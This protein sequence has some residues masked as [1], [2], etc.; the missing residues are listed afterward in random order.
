M[1][2]IK[3][4]DDLL[5]DAIDRLVKVQKQVEDYLAEEDMLDGDDSSS[6]NPIRDK[7][8][9]IREQLAQVQDT[10]KPGSGDLE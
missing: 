1:A 5:N 9:R 3:E 2:T 6:L 8:Q 10:L 7:A 4:V